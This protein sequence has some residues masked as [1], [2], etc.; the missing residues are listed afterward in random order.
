MRAITNDGNNN[1]N[2][3]WRSR[4]SCVAI[5]VICWI[6]IIFAITSHV[7]V[8]HT[9]TFWMAEIVV[10]ASR[11]TVAMPHRHT[12]VQHSLE[13]IIIII[14]LTFVGYIKIAFIINCF[15]TILICC[16]GSYIE[17]PYLSSPL[18]A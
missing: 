7:R 1:N 11:Q 3:Y 16:W 4:V 10:C 18:C 2:R 14:I 13:I 15:Q 12:S 8:Y 9:F 5:C 6:F 17:P